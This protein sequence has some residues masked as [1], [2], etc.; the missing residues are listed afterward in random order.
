MSENEFQ[1]RCLGGQFL[2]ADGGDGL[3]L[4]TA[5]EPLSSGTFYIQ[6][7][8]RRVHIKLL[9]GGYVQVL[10]SSGFLLDISKVLCVIAPR[11]MSHAVNKILQSLFNLGNK[12]S[13]AYFHL[14]IRT[15]VG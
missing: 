3:I 15:R 14:S 12:R 13:S 7:N 9:S 11:S 1:F 10:P 5:K 8:G 2:T 6:R 4:A